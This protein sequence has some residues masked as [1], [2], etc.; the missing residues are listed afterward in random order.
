MYHAKERGGRRA[1]VSI[2]VGFC[3]LAHLDDALDALR[4]N[5]DG[6]SGSIMEQEPVEDM[7]EQGRGLGKGSWEANQPPFSRKV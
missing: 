3:G 1:I 5:S 4:E 7:L 2:A 6:I